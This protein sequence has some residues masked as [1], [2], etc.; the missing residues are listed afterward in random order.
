MLFLNGSYA[1]LS[2]IPR[3]AGELA[4]ASFGHLASSA[5]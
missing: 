2:W 1:Y 5:P 4:A 3:V